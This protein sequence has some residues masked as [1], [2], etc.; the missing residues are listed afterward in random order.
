MR[1][2][3]AFMTGPDGWVPAIIVAPFIGS[4]LG[5]LITRLP[6]GKAVV[7]ERSR[8]DRCG[9]AL[10]AR[11]LIPLVSFTLSRGQCRYC[12]GAIGVFAPV[13][14]MA[15]LGV[16]FWA[17]LVTSGGNLWL[18]CLLGWWLLTMA[19]IDIETMLLPDTL[20][21]PLLLVGLGSVAWFNPQALPDHLLATAAGYLVLFATAR[22]YRALRGRDGLGLG[23]AK[24]LAA[25]GAW[26]GLAAL[27]ALLFAAASLGL[28][29]ALG[30]AAAG[31]RVV[32]TT[33]IPFGPCLAMSGWLFWLYGDGVGD[34]L[35]NEWL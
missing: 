31:R 28:V 12:R 27:P 16:A 26:L 25:L 20:T 35:A 32:G 9:H 22:T 15:A 19:C 23:D 5:V 3:L 8:C 29:A 14:E 4:F 30:L 34:W 13:I 6:R 21:L 1:D 24:L 7:V 18:T 17:A 10:R 33:A 11:D 2:I